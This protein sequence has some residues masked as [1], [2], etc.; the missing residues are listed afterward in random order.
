M[1]RGNIFTFLIDLT[2]FVI[3]PGKH[4]KITWTTNAALCKPVLILQQHEVIYAIFDPLDLVNPILAI[5]T[6]DFNNKM[7]CL[8]TLSSNF[9]SVQNLFY[10][11]VELCCALILV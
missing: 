3:G 4:N 8:K 6:D 7:L 2:S 10:Y 5:C 1:L 9:V 11:F